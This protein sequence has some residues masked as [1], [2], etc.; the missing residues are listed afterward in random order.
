MQRAPL[1]WALSALAVPAPPQDGARPA[2][3]QAAAIVLTIPYGTDPNERAELRLPA[4][5]GPFPVAV[6]IHGG[7][8][9]AAGGDL[10][11][12]APLAAA[13]TARGIATWNIEYRRPGNPGGGYPGTFEDIA[14]ATDY[15][16]R[17]AATPGMPL[18]LKR[19]AVVGHDAGAHLALWLAARPK[20]HHPIAGAMTVR[21]ATV[22]AIDGVGTLIPWAARDTALCGKSVIVPFM[23]GTPRDKAEAYVLASPEAQLPLGI[24]Q[25]LVQ[26]SWLPADSYAG[27]ALSSGD[28]VIKLA[29]GGATHANL[30]HPDTPQ[31]KQVADFVA[32]QAFAH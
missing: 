11:D 22:V 23:G 26:G 4:G 29:P 32:A 12:T 9:K 19:V 6:V 16:A 15:L 8:W 28:T 18:D 14:A 13:L 25:I 30:I 10:H 21:P 5:A 17:L 24:H 3:G 1:L 31:G 7:C 27:S 2:K 20:L